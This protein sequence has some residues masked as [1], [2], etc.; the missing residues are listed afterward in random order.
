MQKK[1][2][3]PGLMTSAVSKGVIDHI[4]SQTLKPITETLNIYVSNTGDDETGD[5]SRARPFRT[6][7]KANDYIALNYYF[8]VTY[9][10]ANITF[11]SDYDETD[12]FIFKSIV[13]SS[14]IKLNYLMIN[15]N[16]FNVCFNNVVVNSGYCRFNDV[17]FVPKKNDTCIN[18][19]HRSA[20]GINNCKIIL[21]E[22][23]VK[24][25]S[26]IRIAYQSTMSILDR[27][28]VTTDTNQ[29]INNN[30]VANFFAV[31]ANSSFYTPDQIIFE[32]AFNCTN[33]FIYCADSGEFR[34]ATTS[35]FVNPNNVKG[36]KYQV[37]TCGSLT[38]YGKGATVIPGN[39]EGL[40]QLNGFFS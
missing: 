31:Y 15:G 17:T 7:R 23:S 39:Q 26:V 13:G 37:R 14:V 10:G 4:V 30:N 25:N 40:V 20:G 8:A 6:L 22:S 33:A 19:E 12:Q 36:K 9:V 34:V 5:G 35:K 21:S 28:T 3:I 1:F 11:L 18:F 29:D 2:Y 32:H 38:T 16:G 27:L 24:L